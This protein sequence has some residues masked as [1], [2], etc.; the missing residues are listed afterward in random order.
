MEINGF[1][2]HY[3]DFYKCSL[4]EFLACEQVY[5]V[6]ISPN[7]DCPLIVFAAQRQ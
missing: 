1:P 5:R 3:C 4:M 2:K 7:Q 6:L